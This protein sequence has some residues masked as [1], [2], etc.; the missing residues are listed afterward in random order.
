MPENIKLPD[1]AFSSIPTEEINSN[2][3]QKLIEVKSKEDIDKLRD[4]CLLGR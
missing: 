2:Y 1:Y 3:S 4:S